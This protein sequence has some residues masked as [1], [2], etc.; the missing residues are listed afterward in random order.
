MDRGPYCS[1]PNYSELNCRG[2][3][4][5]D[6]NLLIM[7]DYLRRTKGIVSYTYCSLLFPFKLNLSHTSWKS[8]AKRFA[9]PIDSSL[10]RFVIST[11][12]DL[13]VMG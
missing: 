5:V 13:K 3:L 12:S 8:S 6:F 10:A 11:A 2:S 9:E 7:N 1:S 4:F